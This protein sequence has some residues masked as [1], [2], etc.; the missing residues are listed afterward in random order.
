MRYEFRT[1]DG[2]T[3]CKTDD[4]RLLC[5]QCKAHAQGERT[6]NQPSD[7]DNDHLAAYRPALERLAKAHPQRLALSSR[8]PAVDRALS[9][10]P[11]GEPPNGYAIALA[12]RQEAR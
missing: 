7:F 2:Q 6:M 4:I 5:D 1:A 11:Y 12:A 10:D 8:K 9:G 3:C